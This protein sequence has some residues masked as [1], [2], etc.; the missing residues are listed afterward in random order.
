MEE[1]KAAIAQFIVNLRQEDPEAFNPI[2][3]SQSRE[4]YSTLGIIP[5]V[6]AV[7]LL[8]E[9][10]TRPLI[11]KAFIAHGAHGLRFG[12]GAAIANGWNKTAI[13]DMVK[14]THQ[15]QITE[16][17]IQTIMESPEE[18]I[19]AKTDYQNTQ[20][21]DLYLDGIVRTYEMTNGAEEGY[22][23]NPRAFVISLMLINNAIN[24]ISDPITYI[25]NDYSEL[26]QFYSNRSSDR[27]LHDQF[28]KYSLLELRD[29]LNFSELAPPRLFDSINEVTILLCGVEDFTFAYLRR[30]RRNNVF[31]LSVK[32]SSRYFM[33]GNFL[34]MRIQEHLETGAYFSNVNLDGTLITKLYNDTYET[35]WINVYDNSITFEEFQNDF[36]IYD[37]YFVTQVLHCEY[38]KE[39]DSYFI[40]HLDHEFIFYDENEYEKRQSDSWQKVNAR[41]R[42]KTFK[43][44]KGRIPIE[45]NMLFDLLE[46][47]FQHKDLI[48]EYFGKVAQG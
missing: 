39:N 7:A 38:F 26:R 4:R 12:V 21:Q 9:A 19:K 30:L 16:A 8:P 40:N 13:V 48:R 27:T 10:N 31:D 37:D 35:L 32:P 46:M 5:V 1:V 11:Q 14:D 24:D 18:V 42:I 25:A 45:T 6:N 44:D 3:M 28:S 2:S 43:I 47:K 34:L 33:E 29:G 20:R 36:Q 41:K 17:E 22:Q 23:L 15:F